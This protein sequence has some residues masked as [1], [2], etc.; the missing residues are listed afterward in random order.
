MRKCCMPRFLYTTLLYCII[1][2]VPLKLLWRGIKQPAYLQHWGERFGFYKTPPTKPVIWLHCVSVGETRAAQPIV[3]ALKTEYPNHQILLSHATPTGRE[4][5]EQLFG[6]SVQRVY[7]PYDV[8]FAVRKFIQH[9]KPVLG[10][11]MET[12]LWF[13]LITAC[14]KNNTPIILINGRLSEKSAHGYAKLGQLT[15]KGLSELSAVAAQTEDDARRLKALGANNVSVLGNV[16][17][18]VKPPENVA[19][20]V[21]KLRQLLG[22]YKTVFLAASTRE[23]EEALILKAIS[24]IDVLTMIVP[25]HPQRFDEVEKLIQSHH[26]NYVR[27]SA[28]KTVLADDV[29]IVLGDTMGELFTYYGACDFTLVGGSLLKL[30]GQNL[31]EAASMGKPILIGEHT[32]NFAEASKTALATGAAIQVNDV[33]TL[34]ENIGKLATEKALRNSMGKAA[35]DFSNASAGAV[36]RTMKLISQFMKPI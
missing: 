23:G 14:K 21:K 16:K 17:F 25:R 10:L 2:F 34:Q 26:L 9:F 12:E 30:G 29:Q 31:I 22:K 7:L 11:L 32:F 28:L 33:Q 4:T 18:D 8:P 1:P 5:S 35:K 27:K 3:N 19:D 15:R 36:D 6:D 24:N 13:N 20:N